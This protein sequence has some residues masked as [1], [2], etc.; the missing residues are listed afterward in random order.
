MSLP[1]P[2]AT[3]P[4]PATAQLA[5][6]TDEIE[7][8]RI[9]LKSML[10]TSFV[11]S[12]LQVMMA[13]KGSEAL[14]KVRDETK[15]QEKRSAMATALMT[16]IT[17]L[18]HGVVHPSDVENPVF[19]AQSPPPQ[20]EALMVSADG[21]TS[22]FVSKVSDDSWSCALRALSVGLFGT[23]S[24]YVG[25]AYALSR[26]LLDGMVLPDE[27]SGEEKSLLGMIREE[28]RIPDEKSDM[29]AV[30]RFWEA[31]E[32]DEVR[33]GVGE[34][35]LLVKLLNFNTILCYGAIV[36]GRA[37]V[38][39]AE[40]LS[41]SMPHVDCSENVHV[42]LVHWKRVDRHH[43][44]CF[45]V[46]GLWKRSARS[47]F[48]RTL[49]ANPNVIRGSQLPPIAAAPIAKAPPPPP[50]S[51]ALQG[52]PA[53]ASGSNSPALGAQPPPAA[54]PAASAPILTGAEQP[55]SAAPGAGSL[56][57]DLSGPAKSGAGDWTGKVSLP[58]VHNGPPPFSV[59][60]IG[61]V[62]HGNH[63]ASRNGSPTPS[64]MRTPYS[65]A[66]GL[67]VD[68]HPGAAFFDLYGQSGDSPPVSPTGKQNP[69]M[70]DHGTPFSGAKH[71]G[72]RSTPFG[73]SSMTPF[74]SGNG[75]NNP[76]GLVLAQPNAVDPA[77]FWAGVG[78]AHSKDI[79][80]QSSPYTL[81]K[82]GGELSHPQLQQIKGL[83]PLQDCPILKLGEDFLPSNFRLVFTWVEAVLEKVVS[84]HPTKGNT[85]V[86][87]FTY[88]VRAHGYMLGINI[89]DREKIL[90]NFQSQVSTLDYFNQVWAKR[91][92][93]FLL[94]ALPH[95][96]R[97]KIAGQKH[98]WESRLFSTAGGADL[99]GSNS[100]FLQTLRSGLC[101]PDGIFL[102][103]LMSLYSNLGD[104][105]LKLQNYLTGVPP[106]KTASEFVEKFDKWVSLIHS[107]RAVGVALP[108]AS[109]VWQ[110]FMKMLGPLRAECITIEHYLQQFLLA[111]PNPVL[112]TD[113]ERVM[114]MIHTVS[115]RL[116]QMFESGT[117]TFVK[118][119]KA[120]PP[121]QNPNGKAPQLLAAAV[122][123]TDPKA[124][125]LQAKGKG[126]G[127]SA[128]AK[129][130]GAKDGAPKA[131]SAK[132]SPPK[133]SPKTPPS[134]E[135]MVVCIEWCENNGVCSKG[136]NC[137][138]KSGHKQPITAAMKEA[139][140]RVIAA[141]ARKIAAKGKG[142]GKGVSVRRF[143][144]SG[145]GWEARG[146]DT[147]HPLDN[148]DEVPQFPPL[149]SS[150]SQSTARRT[151]S[152][153]VCIEWCAT[154]GFCTKG[155]SC[156]YHAGHVMP[157][158]NEMRNASKAII[159][160]RYPNVAVRT[161]ARSFA[162]FPE[163]FVQ[164][165][166]GRMMAAG[167]TPAVLAGLPA[168]TNSVSPGDLSLDP[169]M[170][171]LEVER[172]LSRETKGDHTQ[173]DVLV[174]ASTLPQQGRHGIDQP[175][176]CRVA[177]RY[178]DVFGLSPGQQAE[179]QQ[180]LSDEL[181]E[182]DPQGYILY[183]KGQHLRFR[184]TPWNAGEPEH[185]RLM[186]LYGQPG[187]DFLAVCTPTTFSAYVEAES[188]AGRLYVRPFLRYLE[189]RWI[190][191]QRG[192]FAPIHVTRFHSST[193]NVADAVA[194][195]YRSD[196]SFPTFDVD[197]AYLQVPSAPPESEEAF[198]PG[199]R[200]GFFGQKKRDTRKE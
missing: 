165:C 134:S 184:P 54:V 84:T 8:K 89:S 122:S 46:G 22:G 82:E 168:P 40:E 63:G 138:H 86:S 36:D 6:A 61:N 132:D 136:A 177:N 174:L 187:P 108:D 159:I 185:A 171:C 73:G 124:Q 112:A 16:L 20:Y 56:Y 102:V 110:A 11:A 27:E 101:T 47:S 60:N 197:E 166:D 65:T 189:D 172:M 29:E 121:P 176:Y 123:P 200:K 173:L 148:L 100:P 24:G 21:A 162:D 140:Q 117:L 182:W 180:W 152:A 37:E 137:L 95:H 85:L 149:L 42:Y 2:N 76:L 55:K 35:W 169:G 147:D 130:G 97:V 126:K 67:Q 96:I 195:A 129:A 41:P 106:V 31:V 142:K 25:L 9:E 80:V 53:V 13:M 191:H 59:F 81:L 68:E 128:D 157:I 88:A 50:A 103:V 111:N 1:D 14:G 91:V 15:D 143:T 87:M 77:A 3:A 125:Q 133:N 158:T 141:R 62:E 105:R 193:G 10:S 131:P 75:Q 139:C 161:I 38:E 79:T 28:L 119:P 163:D 17:D 32:A 199:F 198:L 127:K 69:F 98:T 104:Q 167:I 181:E 145:F 78:S 23:E 64:G 34:I 179:R 116:L 4:D 170:I 44:D 74:A 33:I 71:P 39:M 109:L 92:T 18:P 144:L 30:N 48:G 83:A 26:A 194:H 52:I 153:V 66:A 183:L 186:H 94:E 113:E 151:G 196:A 5:G 115:Q 7:K 12:E 156:P 175:C 154:G 164:Q 155:Q 51:L 70:A 120:P 107:V 150:P 146:S 58:S 192:L 57:P 49:A 160:A 72:D 114:Y 90:Q 19:G 178:F 135:Q 45:T 43:F 93:A 190:E 99:L 118:K 188:Q